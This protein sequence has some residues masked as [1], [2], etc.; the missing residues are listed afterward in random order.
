MVKWSNAQDLVDIGL[1][2]LGLQGWQIVSSTPL[3]GLESNSVII[4]LSRPFAD[5]GDDAT[6]VVTMEA[7]TPAATLDGP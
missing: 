5:G 3:A 1:T 4:L 6:A 2:D 7:S